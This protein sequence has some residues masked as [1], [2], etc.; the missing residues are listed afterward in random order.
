MSQKQF[1]PERDGSNVLLVMQSQTSV[2][3]FLGKVHSSLCTTFYFSLYCDQSGH[4]GIKGKQSPEHLRSLT[5]TSNILA[6]SSEISAVFSIAVFWLIAK[7]QIPSI[8]S[9]QKCQLFFITTTIF[10]LYLSEYHTTLKWPFSPQH[11]NK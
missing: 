4:G 2:I 9:V 10:N 7:T 1:V 5:A 8:S 11:W 6:C 3:S